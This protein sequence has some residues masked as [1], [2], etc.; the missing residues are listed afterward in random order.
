MHW[1]KTC[2]ARSFLFSLDD[3][4][5]NLLLN[6][7]MFRYTPWRKQHQLA[8][9]RSLFIPPR[10]V[11]KPNIRKTLYKSLTPAWLYIYYLGYKLFRLGRWTFMEPTSGHYIYLGYNLLT[12]NF[13]TA[14]MCQQQTTTSRCRTPPLSSIDVLPCRI[15]LLLNV[16]ASPGFNIWISCSVVHEGNIV[17]NIHNRCDTIH[18]Q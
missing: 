5:W 13:K 14:C 15:R 12:S 10:S 3:N 11:S 17:T 9:M 4:T 16:M 8:G 2:F 6:S 18:V 7:S 1:L